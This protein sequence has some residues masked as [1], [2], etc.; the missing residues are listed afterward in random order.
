MRWRDTLELYL[1]VYTPI[2]S[3]QNDFISFARCC[4]LRCRASNGKYEQPYFSDGKNQ[5]KFHDF[6]VLASIEVTMPSSYSG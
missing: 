3:L 4:Y 2:M 5:V 6:E 1:V